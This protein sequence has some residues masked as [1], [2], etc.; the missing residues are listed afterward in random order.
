MNFA[1]K[2]E[3]FVELSGQGDYLGTNENSSKRLFASIS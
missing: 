3:P 2:Y 1:I